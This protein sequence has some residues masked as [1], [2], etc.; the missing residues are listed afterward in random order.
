M[1]PFSG[2]IYLAHMHASRT[3]PQLTHPIQLESYLTNIPKG[4][5]EEGW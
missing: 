4:E 5:W 1:R 2:R 3:Y